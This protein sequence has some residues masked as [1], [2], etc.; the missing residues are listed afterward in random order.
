MWNLIGS[1]VEAVGLLVTGW[2]IHETWKTAGKGER[3]WSPA[4]R[5]MGTRYRIATNRVR[6]LIGRPRA[7]TRQTVTS[8]RDTAWAVDS[9]HVELTWAGLDTDLDT[10]QAL[11]ELD[12]RLRDLQRTTNEEARMQRDRVFALEAAE[13]RSE[14]DR[15]AIRA[16][17]DRVTRELPA[18][19]IR[20]EA[21]GLSM[22]GL[23]LLIQLVAGIF[24]L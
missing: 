9:A 3:L 21:V 10:A 14:N 2:G 6:A 12:R 22:V 4:T 20:V 17:L 1:F 18:E 13:R 5:W 15:D 8:A 19:G 11:A 7:Q 23:G 16:D 24:A